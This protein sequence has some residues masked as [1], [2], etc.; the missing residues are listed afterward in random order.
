MR[1]GYAYFPHEHTMST[2]TRPTLTFYTDIILKDIIRD[3]TN[4]TVHQHTAEQIFHQFKNREVVYVQF[5]GDNNCDMYA[6]PIS[7]P[8]L[9][10]MHHWQSTSERW[11]KARERSRK[12]KEARDIM[13]VNI[14]IVAAAIRKVAEI[15]PDQATVC[16][17]TMIHK[18][19]W[20]RIKK[21]GV[22]KL[23]TSVE[24][25]Y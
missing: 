11:L 24:E 18:E 15:N 9:W 1:I 17:R 10:W 23:I 3:N 7:A 22:G 16:A 5:V 25:I 2:L 4:V 14:K 12:E 8:Q 13:N 19:Q 6:V 21:L 20:D